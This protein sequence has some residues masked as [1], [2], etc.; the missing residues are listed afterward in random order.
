[1][2]IR[3]TAIPALL[4]KKR[5]HFPFFHSARLPGYCLAIHVPYG[6]TVT[7]VANQCRDG[8]ENRKKERVWIRGRKQTHAC[9]PAAL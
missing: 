2:R 7:L 6:Q 1:M 4:R 9:L 3:V 5:K 8:P